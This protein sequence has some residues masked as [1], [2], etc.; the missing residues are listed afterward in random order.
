M[1]KKVSQTK[2]LQLFSQQQGKCY[3]C[4]QTVEISQDSKAGVSVDHKVPKS[5]GGSNEIENL[6]LCCRSCNVLKSNHMDFELLD[7][8]A[9]I[10]RNLNIAE[11][12][13]LKDWIQVVK[14]GFEIYLR[15]ELSPAQA[16]KAVLNKSPIEETKTLLGFACELEFELA[17]DK[18]DM[19]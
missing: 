3:Y 15:S 18:D 17:N 8:L 5:R 2:I 7:C 4:G 11:Q 13:S 12:M 1:T 6:V 14:Q 19:H 10:Y 9:R 16:V